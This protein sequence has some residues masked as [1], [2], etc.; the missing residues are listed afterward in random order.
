M[1]T[2]S[3]TTTTNFIGPQ[4]KGSRVGPLT[5]SVNIMAEECVIGWLESE[6]SVVQRLDSWEERAIRFV[7]HLAVNM[8]PFPFLKWIGIT[9][10]ESRKL[11]G[12]S[13]DLYVVYE[14]VSILMISVFIKSSLS[15]CR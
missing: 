7:I 15:L 11:S 6:G 2:T 9:E 1:T 13:I 5:K 4:V 8:I 14:F 12:D 10:S 3:M